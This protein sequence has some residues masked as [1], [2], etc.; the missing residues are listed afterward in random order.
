M[1]PRALLAALCIAAINVGCDRAAINITDPPITVQAESGGTGRQSRD[2]DLVV[3]DYR[4]SLPDGTKLLEASNYQFIL[5]EGS[6][7]SGIDETV[8][9]MQSGGRRVVQ[10]PPHLHWG[11][12]GYADVVPPNTV[13]TL[14]VRLKSIQ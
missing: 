10:C 9:G 8:R 3:I 12:Q 1:L 6:V 5:G 14:D 7:I 2:G 11:R 13:L 4:I